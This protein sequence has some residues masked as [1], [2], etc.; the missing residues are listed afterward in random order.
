M[1]TL[2]WSL[3]GL[4]SL[5]IITVNHAKHHFTEAVGTILFALY[6]MFAV[7]VMLNAL[8]AMMSNTY[9]RVEVWHNPSK[10]NHIGPKYVCIVVSIFYT[11]GIVFVAALIGPQ[12]FTFSQK[13]YAC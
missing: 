3:F 12:R 13:Y 7:V 5:E 8:I 1:L 4:E 10:S 9:T 6:M 2:F 11:Y